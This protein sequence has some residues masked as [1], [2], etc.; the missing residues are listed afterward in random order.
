[1]S[2]LFWALLTPFAKK[3]NFTKEKRKRKDLW[4]NK[5]PNNVTLL[6]DSPL[7]TACG[8]LFNNQKERRAFF[9]LFLFHWTDSRQ[10]HIIWK[11]I[12]YPVKN[13]KSRAR[14]N[15]FEIFSRR[16]NAF[17]FA[18]KAACDLSSPIFGYVK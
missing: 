17:C 7:A 2:I 18:K 14:N 5:T 15:I 16:R 3:V 10:A 8:A 11:V 1:M 13:K 6:K 12:T 4:Y 9:F